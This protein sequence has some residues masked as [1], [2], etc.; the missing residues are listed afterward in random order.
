MTRAQRQEIA[1][2]KAAGILGGDRFSVITEGIDNIEPVNFIYIDRHGSQQEVR[3]VHPHSFFETPADP[4]WFGS[5]LLWGTHRVHRT[6]EQFRVERIS[7]VIL[8]SRWHM[9]IW[10]TTQHLGFSGE[11][12][13]AQ[14]RSVANFF[15]A[16][17]LYNDSQVADLLDEAADFA[18]ALAAIS[19]ET[20]PIPPIHP[21]PVPPVVPEPTYVHPVDIW[22]PPISPAPSVDP[23]HVYSMLNSLIDPSNSRAWWRGEIRV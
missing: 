14:F 7:A 2:S 3:E 8:F 6:R 5:V 9:A 19:S 20:F 21:A 11:F 13:A 4:D 18:A 15:R 10:Y 12:T 16:R 17:N 23:F 22:I 1:R